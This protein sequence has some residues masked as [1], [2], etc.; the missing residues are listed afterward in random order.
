MVSPCRLAAA[1][2]SLSRPAV[3]VLRFAVVI[4]AVD[5]SLPPV[6]KKAGRPLFAKRLIASGET[7]RD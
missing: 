2:N 1:L 7:T 6:M 5:M 4:V 3:S